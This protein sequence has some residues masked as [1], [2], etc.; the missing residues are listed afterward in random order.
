MTLD[1]TAAATPKARSN[2]NA[3][4]GWWKSALIE[5]QEMPSMLSGSDMLTK[6]KQARTTRGTAG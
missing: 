3:P 1:S 5:D 2:P 4:R 6:A